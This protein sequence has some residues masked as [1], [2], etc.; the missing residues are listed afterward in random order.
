MYQD[1]MVED[2]DD[3]FEGMGQNPFDGMEQIFGMEGSEN[4]LNLYQK[5]G[6]E[7]ENMENGDLEDDPT[8]VEQMDK[9]DVKKKKAELLNKIKSFGL[10]TAPV[11]NLLGP[12]KGIQEDKAS[13]ETPKNTASALDAEIEPSMEND[14]GEA[15]VKG[16]NEI[17]DS[18]PTTQTVNARGEDKK[19]K[20]K[21]TKAVNPLVRKLK[22][23]TSKA[24]KAQEL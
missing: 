11:D 18:G 24:K 3:P 9:E 21:R 1:M 13:L 19:L 16:P 22:K 2:Y 20:L 6:E 4:V 8:T 23:K 7:I 10:P 17:I 15:I 12:A 14:G 5:L